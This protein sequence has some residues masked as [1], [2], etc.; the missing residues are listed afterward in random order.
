MIQGCKRAGGPR[1]ADN[2]NRRS[3]RNMLEQLGFL[4]IGCS[5]FMVDQ[6]VP[7]EMVKK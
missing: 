2:E 3:R 1:S 5:N 4:K 7:H 6:Y